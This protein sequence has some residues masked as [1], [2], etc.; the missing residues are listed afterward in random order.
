M[1]AKVHRSVFAGHPLSLPNT[2]STCYSV[3]TNKG[4][5]LFATGRYS[6]HTDPRI[7]TI[8]RELFPDHHASYFLAIFRRYLRRH[9]SYTAVQTYTDSAHSGTHLLADGWVFVANHHGR[10]RWVRTLA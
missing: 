8:T 3:T 4:Q 10:K 7:L 1:V 6:Q 9:T 2:S 5:A